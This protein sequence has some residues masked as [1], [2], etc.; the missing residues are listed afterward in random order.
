MSE[1][2]SVGE[3]LRLAFLRGETV[4]LGSFSEK[5]G[6]TRQAVHASLKRFGELVVSKKNPDAPMTQ[7]FECIDM[8]GMQA[9]TPAPYRGSGRPKAAK[10]GCARANTPIGRLMDAWGIGP[11]DIALPYMRHQM[12]LSDDEPEAA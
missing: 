4:C 9:F 5:H 6:V 7:L 10:T 11:A 3:H 2:L 8:A 12:A 1:R